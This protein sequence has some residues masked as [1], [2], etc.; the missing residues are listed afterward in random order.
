MDALRKAI[1]AGEDAGK[2]LFLCDKVLAQDPKSLLATHCRA[3][4]LLHSNGSNP[5]KV[6]SA[7]ASFLSLRSAVEK[8]QLT[9]ENIAETL[10]IPTISTLV[11]QHAYALYRQNSFDEVIALLGESKGVYV[12]DAEDCSVQHL[13][14]Q[15]YYNTERF[16]D[17]A[18]VYEALL[19]T[20][21]DEE[22]RE[23]IVTN[24]TACYA[25][26]GRVEDC[27]AAIRKA[28]DKLFEHLFNGATAAIENGDAVV[29]GDLLSKAETLLRRNGEA[30]GS[31]L[32]SLISLDEMAAAIASRPLAG[33]DVEFA[34]DFSLILVQRAFLAH[35]FEGDTASAARILNFIL[36]LG[37][38]TQTTAA[39]ASVNLAAIRGHADFFE[40]Y[41]A[42]KHVQTPLV[43]SR[44]NRRQRRVV[45]FNTAL[46][47]LNM[48]KVGE[49]KR[50]AS[51]LVAN[52]SDWG[53]VPLLL[54]AVLLSE[55]RLTA[56]AIEDALDKAIGGTADVA[57]SGLSQAAFKVLVVAQVRLR[58]GDVAGAIDAI[59]SDASLRAFP[60]VVATLCDLQLS[61]GHLAGASDL[62]KGNQ[63]AAEGAVLRVSEHLIQGDAHSEALSLL[64]SIAS[65]NT[66]VAMRVVA[67]SATDLAGAAALAQ[68][69]SVPPATAKATEVDDDAIEAATGRL[70][71]RSDIEKSGF[72]PSSLSGEDTRRTGNRR[73]PMRRPCKNLKADAKLDYERWLPLSI[74][75]YYKDLPERRKR[76]MRRLRRE[77]QLTKRKQAEKRKAEVAST[78]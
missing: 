59:M 38:G 70:P 13:L 12:V 17:A 50:I 37:V 60:A 43:F 2:F 30:S 40:S 33:A 21:D 10:G 35:R 77:E 36:S 23:N 58:S 51:D 46:L 41:R 31:F 27:E 5:H 76:E 65:S 4:A 34:D 44:L 9:Q 68:N 11:F 48:G 69:L 53:L 6:A 52:H 72:M 3:I 8:N 67:Q 18:V 32:A 71:T 22:D 25:A 74:R 26:M 55:R 39:I 15:S 28:D 45:K 47:L 63:G 1:E 49:C 19:D 57:K 64:A 61:T 14:A 56:S 75:T 7:L 24:L 62:L 29:A 16:S 42:L 78:L 73:R 20:S 66:V 54:V